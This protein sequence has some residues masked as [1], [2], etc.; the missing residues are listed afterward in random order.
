MASLST[1]VKH[2]KPLR[3]GDAVSLLSPSG[4]LHNPDD[5]DWSQQL[6]EGWGY[7]VSQGKTTKT[8]HKFFSGQDADRADDLNEAFKKSKAIFCNRGGN[9][10]ARVLPLL[11]Y[12]LLAK[13]P[14]LLTGFS[15]LSSLHGAFLTQANLASLHSPVTVMGFK[16]E[17]GKV[18]P[19]CAA[20]FRRFLT[21]TEPV[22]SYNEALNWG[23]T[24]SLTK[25][26]AK[27]Q[28]IGGNLAVFLALLGTKYMPNPA[29]K[30]LFIEDIN[31]E[32][33]RVDRMIVQLKLSGYIDQLVGLVLGQ[34]TD[35]ESDDSRNG[36][37]QDVLTEQFSTLKIP[38]LNNFPTGHCPLNAA[39]PF[40]CMVE[41]DADAGDLIALEAFCQE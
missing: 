28:L 22:G 31:E 20:L 1:P 7:K 23:G 27:G 3:E 36:T 32:P 40:G 41:V 16:S 34:F 15:D 38:V 39:L 2:P 18:T 8:R 17:T 25:G 6:I 35:C 12:Q 9:G 29:G 37:A 24:Q 30:I 21:S 33:Y 5:A 26:K 10:L 19:E 14:V 4:P 13:N 11:D